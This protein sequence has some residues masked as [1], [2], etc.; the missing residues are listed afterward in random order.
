MPIKTESWAPDFETTGLCNHQLLVTRYPAWK[1][2]FATSL[3]ENH[4][5]IFYQ[6]GITGGT[7][8]QWDTGVAVEDL[9]DDLKIFV[10]HY[11][12]HTSKGETE[13]VTL[14]GTG[15]GGDNGNDEVPDLGPFTFI[16][17]PS[18]NNAVAIR[19]PFKKQLIHKDMRKRATITFPKT[20]VE[21][22]RKKPKRK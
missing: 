12:L 16:T 10:T 21:V 6:E 4:I 2:E 14:L 8:D 11:N 5:Y 22:A 17:V 3:E 9:K 13:E 20:P 19:I 15:G 7:L 18:S 1:P